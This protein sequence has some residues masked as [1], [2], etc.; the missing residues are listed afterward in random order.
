M[1]ENTY[2]GST[3]PASAG[4]GST[5]RAFIVTGQR[6]FTLVERERHEPSPGQVRIRVEAC[7][8]CH[9]DVLA[10]EGLRPDPSAPIVPG[11]EIIGVI[12]AL[13]DGVDPTWQ[14]GD[15]VGVGFLGGQDNTCQACRR[16]DFVNC[17]D[18]PQT[19]TGIDG[20]YA[21]VTYAR[22]TGLVR[23]PPGLDA[24]AGAPLLCAGL[25]MYNAL[26]SASARPGSLV[27]V[28]G[29]GGLGHLGIQ[30]ARALGH[31][32]VAIARGTAKATLAAELG[33]HHYIDST[34]TDPGAALR[35]LGGAAVIVATAAS[36]ASMSPL[37]QG[38]GRRGELVVVGAAPDPIQVA[39]SDLIFGE[40]VVRGSLTGTAI[41]NEDNLHFT[42]DHGIRS[43]NEVFPLSEAPKAYQHMI[44]G[45][46]RFR[47]VLD[48]TA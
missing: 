2:R 23:I 38:L 25:T 34:Q 45:D 29:I 14:V 7:G 30:Y 42:L 28:Q 18:Q 36:G 15:R 32:V 33:A 24:L 16:G 13:G 43:H 27:A 41:E 21:E 46:A 31:R 40:H 3:H 17:S 47:A 26:I 9:T 11:H 20:G 44:N 19:G 39:T 10:V 5:Y 22:A 1:S 8:I 35:Q 37:L 12:E 6:Q 4:Q 48:P